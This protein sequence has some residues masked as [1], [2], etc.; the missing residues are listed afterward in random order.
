MS[1]GLQNSLARASGS[2]ILDDQAKN[3]E[4][5]FQGNNDEYPGLGKADQ[6]RR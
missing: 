1:E 3:R 4:L 5:S 6:H 2:I